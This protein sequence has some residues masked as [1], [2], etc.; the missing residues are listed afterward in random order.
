MLT[1][2]EAIRA[3]GKHLPRYDAFDCGVFCVDGAFHDALRRTIAAGEPGSISAGVGRLARTGE[4][5]TLTI[6]DRWWI[7]VDDPAALAQAEADIAA[8]PIVAQ[9]LH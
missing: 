9:A 4:A 5:R 3:I 7:D 8:I 1:E 6:G 2:G